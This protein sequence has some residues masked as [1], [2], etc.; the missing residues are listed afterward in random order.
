VAFVLY[1]GLQIPDGKTGWEI[2]QKGVLLDIFTSN[3][4]L[5]DRNCGIAEGWNF[6]KNMLFSRF[7]ISSVNRVLHTI[8]SLLGR[9]TL[10]LRPI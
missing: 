1:L 4:H 7:I 5:C 6:G 3:W 10:D 8:P 2:L 9:D